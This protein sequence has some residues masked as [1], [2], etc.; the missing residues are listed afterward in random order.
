M[1]GI[2]NLRR[3]ATA[4][5]VS[6]IL[7]Y[8]YVPTIQRGLVVFGITRGGSNTVVADGDLVVIQGT[9]HCEDIHHHEPSQSLFLACEGA[10]SP[11]REWF[12]PLNIYRS[13]ERGHTAQAE[14]RVIDTK[15]PNSH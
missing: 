9:R 4:V 6:A 2:F 5:G 11:R 8:Q 10:D 1:P 14:F 12:P 13:S 3:V 7:A 15:V